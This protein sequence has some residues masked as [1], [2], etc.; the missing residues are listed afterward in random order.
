MSGSEEARSHPALVD[1]QT[2]LAN[3]LQF[4]LVYNYLFLAGN[5]GLAFSVMLVSGGSGGSSTTAETQSL[6]RVIQATTRNSDLVSH[7]GNGRFA[8]LLL[9][10]NLQG[11]RIAA[12]RIESALDDPARGDLCVG[13]AAY[14]DGIPEAQALLRSADTALLAAEAA[15]GGLEFA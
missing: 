12:D 9:G 15:G 14:S 2:G 10:T 13:L 8:V 6:G 4:D 11:A 1:A 5:R 7:M 3:Q